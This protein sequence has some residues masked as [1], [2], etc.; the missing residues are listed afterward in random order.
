MDLNNQKITGNDLRA[1][2][3]ND[4]NALAEGAL[5]DSII[6]KYNL[7]ICYLYGQQTKVDFNEAYK[8]FSKAAEGNDQVS[9]LFLGYMYEHGLGVTKSYSKALE[10]YE[11]YSTNIP[12]YHSL[13]KEAEK[14]DE[15][16]IEQVLIDLHSKATSLARDLVDIKNLC[17]YEET[18]D[19]FVFPW[20]ATTVIQLTKILPEYNKIVYKF[21]IYLDAYSSDNDDDKLGKWTY[22]YLDHHRRVQLVLNAL[23]GRSKLTDQLSQ[24]G[25]S[26]IPGDAYFEFAAGRCLIDDNDSTDNDFIISGI[27]LIAGHD[28]EPLWQNIVGLWYE[29]NEVNKD[30]LEAERWYNRALTNNDGSA[31]SNLIRLHGKKAYRLSVDSSEGTHDDRMKIAM[32]FAENKENQNKWLIDAAIG[33]NKK[34]HDYLE[35]SFVVSDYQVLDD[36][37][38]FIPYWETYAQEAKETKRVQYS[39]STLMAKEVKDYVDAVKAAKDKAERDRQNAIKAERRRKMEEERRKRKAEE[40]AR[41]AAEK[42]EKDRLAAEAKAKKKAEEERE[43]RFAEQIEEIRKDLQVEA[44]HKFVKKCIWIIVIVLVIVIGLGIFLLTNEE[45]KMFLQDNFGIS[46]D[47]LSA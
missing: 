18:N 40:A 23:L 7:G 8:W 17:K 1:L 28:E 41:R 26:M 38:K 21:K 30:L 39:W 32:D 37:D 47:N 35:S 19:S 46:L 43:A 34:A 44:W 10:L 14:L 36:E 9:G 31:K 33:G 5:G 45:T 27:Q 4:F 13:K 16:Q 12:E 24:E 15:K 2:S 42:E 20:D 29:Y 3:L 11:K 25:F 22:Y 6:A